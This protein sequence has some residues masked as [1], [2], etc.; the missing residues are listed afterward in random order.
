MIAASGLAVAALAAACTAT[1]DGAGNGRYRPSTGA[2]SSAPSVSAG[3]SAG[4]SD[5]G[6]P[7]GSASGS[8]HAPLRVK[9]VVAPSGRTYVIKIWAERKDTDCAAH[10]YGAPVIRYLHQHPCS[11]LDRVLATTR[12]HG[13]TVEFAQRSIGF[14][15]GAPGS[16]RAAA[17]FRKLVSKNGTGNLNDLLREGGRIPG[18]RK[19]V[20]FPN[21]FS[22]LAQDNNVTVVEAWYRDGATADNDPDLEQMERDTYLQY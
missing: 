1:T 20:P 13:R 10:A 2:P 17:G 6:S 22:A 7:T 15:G 16:Y 18:G 5:S 4:G 11:G 9:V 12:V 8:A 19:S 21:A 3:A 14:A